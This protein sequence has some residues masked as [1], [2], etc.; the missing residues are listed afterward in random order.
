MSEM[1]IALNG[2]QSASFEV[3]SASMDDMMQQVNEVVRYATNILNNVLDL[4]K[5]K[6]DS[7]NLNKKD[8]DLQDLVMR[9]T[10]MQISKAVQATMK[11]VPSPQL[12]IA[13]SDPDVIS[14]ILTN[15]I[16]NAVKFTTEGTIQPFVRPLELLQPDTKASHRDLRLEGR[17]AHMVAIG[18]ADTG[19]GLS[20]GT[21]DCAKTGALDAISG[22][23]ERHGACNSGFG[24]HF[25][26]MLANSLG[27]TLY[28]SSIEDAW[29][30]LSDDSKN[31][32]TIR[33]ASLGGRCSPASTTCTG[34][35]L[36]FTLPAY[37]NESEA[38][39]RLNSTGEAESLRRHDMSSVDQLEFFSFRP[40][41][42]PDSEDGSFRILIADDVLM[43]RKGL[44]NTL[45]SVFTSCP[46]SISTACSAEDVL[47]AAATNTFDLII[48]DNL[49]QHI[50][51]DLKTLSL[52]EEEDH[53]R[54]RVH[55]DMRSMASRADLRSQMADYFQE[56][57]FTMREEDGKLLGVEAMMRLAQ[58]E[59]QSFP[60][61]LLMILSGHNIEVP[62]H[63]GIFVTQ[64]PLKQSDFCS[65]LESAAPLFIRTNQC[66]VSTEKATTDSA[67]N[68]VYNRHGA[69]IF[70][71]VSQHL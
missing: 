5:I 50:P 71:R 41:P 27:S 19:L 43:L 1:A 44:M 54:P 63:L 42:S 62:D 20:K 70:E 24:L 9:A 67:G 31:A 34:T 49:F 28:L 52:Q 3:R 32:A 26:H 11:F 46:V 18:V 6:S 8:I 56:E 33:K 16:S 68:V 15:L 66:T 48:C 13:N 55:F 30:V 29:S 40:R 53:G 59:N 37:A 17:K 57:R 10:K 61:P 45:S 69:Q 35:V 58:T 47:R 14:R 21:F 38:L 12:H 51:T 64:K 23:E 39:E 2:D 36:Y 4:S 60:T 65:L 25:C 7:M 22:G